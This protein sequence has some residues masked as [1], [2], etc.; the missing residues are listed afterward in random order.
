VCRI[1][2]FGGDAH[3]NKEIKVK[4]YLLLDG[5]HFEEPFYKNSLQ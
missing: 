3:S 2:S 5:I 1:N 4:E